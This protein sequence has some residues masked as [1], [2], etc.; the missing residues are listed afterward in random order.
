LL[1][2]VADT[3]EAAMSGRVGVLLPTVFTLLAA[4]MRPTVRSGEPDNVVKGKFPKPPPDTWDVFV[5]FCEKD[6]PYWERIKTHLEPMWREG[7]KIYYY[8]MVEPGSI[9]REKARSA[10]L[11]SVV[12]VLLISADYLASDLTE[13]EL[14]DLLRQAEQHGGTRMLVLQVGSCDLS[15]MDRLTRYQRVGARERPLNRLREP[16]Q[17][18]IYVELL[19]AIKKRLIECD[20]YPKSSTADAPEGT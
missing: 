8:D 4:T 10:L 12:A 18:D 11:T 17:D 5:S 13:H 7:V 15:G 19:G 6:R 3:C 16:K 2:R 14:P 20:R 9:I 1:Y